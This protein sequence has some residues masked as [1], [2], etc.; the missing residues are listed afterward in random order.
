MEDL[1]S[2]SKVIVPLR[3]TVNLLVFQPRFQQLFELRSKYS[4]NEIE[5]YLKDLFGHSNQP[6]TIH[7]L[8]LAHALLIDGF[9]YL[10]PE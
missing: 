3:V 9:Y 10:K 7:E 2:S 1:P 8:L 4:L 6:K 5:P